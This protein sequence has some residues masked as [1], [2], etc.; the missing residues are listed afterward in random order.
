MSAY[1]PMGHNYGLAVGVPIETLCGIPVQAEE[2]YSTDLIWMRRKQSLK[3]TLLC[4]TCLTSRQHGGSVS[5]C[6]VH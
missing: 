3:C 4:T 6:M 5:R 1:N 2:I